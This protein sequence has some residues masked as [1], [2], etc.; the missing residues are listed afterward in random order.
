MGKIVANFFIALDGVV[1]APDQ[2]H[3]PY[4][5][6]EMGAVVGAGMETNKAFLMGR[7]MYDEWAA[8]WPTSTDEPF[9]TYFNEV[10]KYVVSSSLENPTVAELDGPPGDVDAVRRFKETS[11]ATSR[12]PA[13]RPPSAGCWPT[14][15]STSSGCSCTRSRSATG[16]GSSRTPR[17]TSS[18]SSRAARSRPG[19][20]TCS[21]RRP[22]D[23]NHVGPG[24][25]LPACLDGGGSQSR[26]RSAIL[27]A[28]AAAGWAVWHADSGYRH[29]LVKYDDDRGEPNRYVNLG[30][31]EAQLS[32]GS[33]DG[34]R[35]VVQWR[36]PDGHGWT[37]PETVWTD[38][39]N[40][41]IENTVRFGGGT[42]AIRRSTRATST[43]TATSTR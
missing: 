8:Y 9:A 43:A 18:S 24:I 41:A 22:A 15:C 37:E 31:G 19:C 38:K 12:C 28:G 5:N 27:L 16:S 2:W 39:K 42:V 34:H 13:A 35:I 14:A 25:N 32:I 29:A 6:D 10:Q 33:P 30:D 26:S 17:P 36:D 3:F 20:S 1:E 11:T 4:F 21:T 23:A 7:T 40:V